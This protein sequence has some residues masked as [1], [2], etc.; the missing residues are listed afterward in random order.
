MYSPEV[1]GDL[2]GNVTG[3]AE[4]AVLLKK[5]SKSITCPSASAPITSSY[6]FWSS[7]IPIVGGI[8][9]AVALET[10]GYLSRSICPHSG[11]SNR[12]KPHGISEVIREKVGI[13]HVGMGMGGKGRELR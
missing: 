9:L 5:L 3:G 10:S 7:V 12:A 1:R 6:R 4:M 2:A 11:G 13:G 8:V